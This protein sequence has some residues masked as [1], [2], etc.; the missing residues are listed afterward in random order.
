MNKST[1]VII[2]VI[3][4]VIIIAAFLLTYKATPPGPVY[5]PSAPANF[6]QWLNSSPTFYQDILS[7]Q[8]ITEAP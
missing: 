8:N 3:I 4:V 6:T 7:A 1:I 2:G 5:N